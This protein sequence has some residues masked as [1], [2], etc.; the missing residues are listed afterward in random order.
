MRTL[1]L[2]L[3]FILFAQCTSHDSGKIKSGDGVDIYYQIK[4]NGDFTLIFVHG[5]SGTSAVWDDQV[6]YFKKYCKVVALDL[7]GF[8]QSG[9]NR[10]DWTIENYGKDIHTLIDKLN[11]ENVVLVGSSMGGLAILSAARTNSDHIKG[12]VSVDIINDIEHYWTKTE[13]ED[14]INLYKTKLR[15]GN[16]KGINDFHVNKESAQRYNDVLPNKMPDF[17]WDMLSNVFEWMNDEM[18]P[19]LTQ[20]DKPLILINSDQVKTD[21]VSISKYSNNFSINI[22]PQTAHFPFWDKPKEFNDILLKEIKTKIL[23]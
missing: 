16:L 7:P 3:T 4:G 2:A 17:W 9:Q 19:S 15:K 11:L 18:K 8:G 10:D 21:T 20:I 6:E 12:L 5:W 22:I 14:E 13:I 1:I 23:Q